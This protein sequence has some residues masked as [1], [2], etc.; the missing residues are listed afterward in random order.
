MLADALET[1]RRDFDRRLALLSE[2]DAGAR[3]RAAFA[4]PVL[5]EGSVKAGESH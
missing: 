5:L 1:L 4:A 3:L 2:R